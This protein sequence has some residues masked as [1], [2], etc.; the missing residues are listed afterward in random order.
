MEANLEKAKSVFN[1]KKYQETIDT[2]NKI[3]AIDP[4]EIEALRIKGKSLSAINQ[5]EEAR[6]YFNQAL[7]LKPDDYEL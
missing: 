2:C 3:L 6:K 7:S 1:Q 4:N 5:T